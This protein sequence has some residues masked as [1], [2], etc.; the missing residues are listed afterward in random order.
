MG[1]F[2]EWLK[3]EKNQRAL[4]LIGAAIAGTVAVLVQ[5]GAIGKKDEAKAEAKP[6]PA[7]QAVSTPVPVPTAA[8]PAITQEAK[9]GDGATVTN[10][11]IGSIQINTGN[12]GK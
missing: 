3:D 12:S 11:A 10:T 6:A 7:A 1:I 5:T 2:W 4:T 8:P 9:G